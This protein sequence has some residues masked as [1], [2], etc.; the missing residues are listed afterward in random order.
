ML[1]DIIVDESKKLPEKLTDI[2]AADGTRALASRGF[3]AVA[4]PGGSVA[5]TFFP[6]L[7]RLAFDWSRTEFFWGDERAVPPSHPD[8]NYG[9]AASLWLGPAHVPAARVHRM[10]ADETDLTLAAEAHAGELAAMLGMPPRLD[11]VLLG[12]GPDGHVCSLFP[13]H[14]LLKDD[15]RFVAPV[16]DSPKPPPQRLTLT[17]PVL[18]AA[19]HLV[20]AAMGE[21]KAGIMREAIEDPHSAL[22]VAIA[23]RHAKRVTFLL[24]TAAAR[25]LAVT[26][27]PER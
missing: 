3:F 20:I 11:L 12:V 27:A 7:A 5:T 2:F 22:P 13:G 25:S 23:A 1:P 21:A 19:E 6:H 26:I 16:L 8:S 24:D 15:R 9:V 18:A 17:M 4:L 10:P 14:P